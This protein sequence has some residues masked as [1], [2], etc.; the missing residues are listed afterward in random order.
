MTQDKAEFL[1]NSFAEKEW[2]ADQN[3]SAIRATRWKTFDDIEVQ[4]FT[5]SGKRFIM[6][7]KTSSRDGFPTHTWAID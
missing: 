6:W 3:Y 7:F 1:F 4:A 2:K 5:S